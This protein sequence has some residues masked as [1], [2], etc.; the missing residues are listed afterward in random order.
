[1]QNFHGLRQTGNFILSTLPRR[2]TAAP[3]SFDDYFE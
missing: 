1:M 3:L 2:S